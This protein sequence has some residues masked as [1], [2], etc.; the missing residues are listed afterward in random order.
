MK[1]MIALF[2]V[3]AAV[4]SLAACRKAVSRADLPAEVKQTLEQLPEAVAEPGGEI[5]ARASLK[6]L[7]KACG[8]KI[9]IPEDRTVEPSCSRP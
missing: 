9:V 8:S 4:L 7:N 5:K 3:A 6:A 2:L 1:R